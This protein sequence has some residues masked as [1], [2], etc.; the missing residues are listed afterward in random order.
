MRIFG[1]LLP[2]HLVI[3]SAF[4]LLCL[5]GIFYLAP[6]MWRFPI[7]T[8]IGLWASFF[9][10]CL[11]IAMAICPSS[12]ASQEEEDIKNNLL[13]GTANCASFFVFSMWYAVSLGPVQMVV[14]AFVIIAILI[15]FTIS[16][17]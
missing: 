7:L 2:T 10:V 8:S 9:A 12:N 5:L 4:F 1:L 11:A 15:A 14:L 3:N 6:E 17:V 16:T 13:V